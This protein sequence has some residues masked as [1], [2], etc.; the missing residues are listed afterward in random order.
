MPIVY[1]INNYYTKFSKIY[2]IVILIAI[3]T[4]AIS[5]GMSFLKN[6]KTD[7]KKIA[8]I[9]CVLSVMISP[10]GFANLVKIIFPLFGYIGLLQIYFII[11]H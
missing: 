5:A 6:I 11:K 7:E 2:G 4:T 9:I 3:F 10:I 1:V 8:L